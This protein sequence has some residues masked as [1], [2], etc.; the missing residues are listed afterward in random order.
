MNIETLSKWKRDKERTQDGRTKIRG[1]QLKLDQK[2]ESSKKKLEIFFIILLIT[3]ITK[4][5]KSL[6]KL[7]TKESSIT[8][9]VHAKDHGDRRKEKRHKY[10]PN[11][12]PEK[13]VQEIEIYTGL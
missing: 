5:L 6:N 12:Q 3:H 13:E 1:T 2:V 9:E 11:I 4:P 7:E 10:V 8:Q